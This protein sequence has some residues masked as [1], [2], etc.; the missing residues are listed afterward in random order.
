MRT[1]NTLGAYGDHDILVW[2]QCPACGGRRVRTSTEGEG[3]RFRVDSTA[4]PCIYGGT[5]Q[6][7]AKPEQ[8]P[9]LSDEERRWFP[10]E[11]ADLLILFGSWETISIYGMVHAVTGKWIKR[12]PLDIEAPDW[13]KVWKL[14]RAH[15]P[16]QD[17]SP[18]RNLPP[19]IHVLKKRGQ[20]GRPDRK[21]ADC[22][23][24]VGRRGVQRFHLLY[25]PNVREQSD[26]RF[27]A[28][29]PRAQ[30]VYGELM[31]EG[32]AE[33]LTRGELYKIIVDSPLIDWA[34]FIRQR[35]VLMRSG[36]LGEEWPPADQARGKQGLR[37][38][39][40]V[41]NPVVSVQDARDEKGKQKD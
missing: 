1:F 12:H 18:I 32:G 15:V 30:L 10:T 33:V 34:D 19:V 36:C 16:R 27:L 38:V 24:V 20:R 23:P 21:R 22:N 14:L 25:R 3:K 37:N 40:L 8:V 26:V 28:L 4:C 31:G 11:P 9:A 17:G 5:W 6:R 7:Y 35:P 39:V 2:V 29:P 13:N 41:P